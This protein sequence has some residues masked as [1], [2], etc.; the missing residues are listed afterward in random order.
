VGLASEG[1]YDADGTIDGFTI[2]GGVA[3]RNVLR[4]DTEGDRLADIRGQHLLLLGGNL[5]AEGTFI[6]I[7]VG[8]IGFNCSFE[9]VHGRGADETGNKLVLGIVV[10]VERPTD[11]LDDT[12]L[13]D[14]DYVCHGQ[15]F[16]L[17]VG[18]VN[19]RCLEAVVQRGDLCAH[20]DTKFCV[21][22]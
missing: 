16:N 9:E 20:L 11:L 14:D 13:H 7:N 10:Q 5:E 8:T 17:V 1:F 19:H 12:E 6:Y 15:G 22:V 21:E 3:E 18:Y 2:L 4:A